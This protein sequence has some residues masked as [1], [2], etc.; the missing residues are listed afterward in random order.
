MNLTNK[1]ARCLF[2]KRFIAHTEAVALMEFALVFPIF[3]LLLF[4]HLIEGR[5]RNVG[6]DIIFIAHI[7]QDDDGDT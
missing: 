1:R 5:R 7:S 3:F 4:G 2:L 6:T